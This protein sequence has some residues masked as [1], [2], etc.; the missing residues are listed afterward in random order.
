LAVTSATTKTRACILH[1]LVVWPAVV[2]TIA[3]GAINAAGEAVGYWRLTDEIR[4]N[5]RADKRLT[6][7]LP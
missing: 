6:P 7:S 4:E 1:A 2:E 5:W 3:L